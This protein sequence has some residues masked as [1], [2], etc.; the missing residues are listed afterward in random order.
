ML[1]RRIN[2][3]FSCCCCRCHCEPRLKRARAFRSRGGRRFLVPREADKFKLAVAQRRRRSFVRLAAASRS[4]QPESQSRYFKSNNER[5]LLSLSLFLR[6]PRP[7]GSRMARHNGATRLRRLRVAA[8][9]PAL[10]Q[11]YPAHPRRPQLPALLCPGLVV[12]ARSCRVGRGKY[13][14]GQN[15][16]SRVATLEAL[17][18]KLRAARRRIQ[19]MNTTKPLAA[20]S[21]YLFFVGGLT[22]N[23][24]AWLRLPAR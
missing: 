20:G 17:N 15:P 24:S 2:R 5:G 16:K 23:L 12:S 4:C 10:A 1:A 11:S 13:L 7:R 14:D 21:H 22:Q 6:R 9:L 18:W 8:A 3:C 19:N